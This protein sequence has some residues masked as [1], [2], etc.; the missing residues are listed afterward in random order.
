MKRWLALDYGSKRIGIAISDPTGF[1]ASPLP[2]LLLHPWKV[3][4]TELKNIIEEK[5]VSGILIGM[6]RNMDGSYGPSS[7]AVKEFI[8]KLKQNIDLE[9]KTIDER[10]STV[11]ASR[12]LHEAGHDSRQQKIKIDSASAQVL[13][14]QFLD[15]QQN[16]F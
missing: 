16:S 14:Q 11:Q 8:E 2:F 1:L 7:Q 6:P 12:M 3:F 15:S 4:V 9:F 13:L 10:L 5:G